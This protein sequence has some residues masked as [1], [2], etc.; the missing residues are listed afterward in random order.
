MLMSISS[1]LTCFAYA[2]ERAVSSVKIIASKIV[3]ENNS[4]D[5]QV[6]GTGKARS[7]VDIYPEVDG[8]VKAVL[9]QANTFVGAGSVLIELDSMQEQIAVR[10][11]EAKLKEAT[12]L[13][14]RYQKANSAGVTEN[15]LSLARH[16]VDIA[17]LE[18]E[19][20]NLALSKRTVKAPFPGWV[21]IP[22]VDVGDRIKQDML[23]TG[24]DD[25][26]Q[27]YVEFEVPEALSSALIPSSPQY[28]PVLSVTTPAYPNRLFKAEIIAKQN[29][30]NPQLRTQTVR[31]MIN[32]EEDLLLTGMSFEVTWHIQ[33]QDYP[34][35]PEIAL[36]WEREGA[37][38]W[39][40][41][42]N[43]AYKE[44]IKVISRKGALVLVDGNLEQTDQ[45]VLE[46]VQR[47]RD[48]TQVHILGQHSETSG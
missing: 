6:I 29:R 26:Q 43:K 20:A 41:R 14:S 4:Y 39:T 18:L 8:Q 30:I 24:L 36:Q 15:D 1:A 37:Y 33:G 10:L 48:G 47:L 12:K 45:V 11:A 31:A 17:Q 42:Q 9:F 46:G 44:P 5:F 23:I 16:N 25:R 34:A 22:N 38:V 35:F 2:Q 21:S 19:Q 7:S 32:N 3:I 13:L 27:I 40:V 28:N